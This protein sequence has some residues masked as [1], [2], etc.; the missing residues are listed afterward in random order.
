MSV[1][2]SLLLLRMPNSLSDRLCLGVFL[3]DARLLVVFFPH[4]SASVDHIWFLSFCLCLL[5]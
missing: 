4:V 2:L 1:A 5:H 3:L